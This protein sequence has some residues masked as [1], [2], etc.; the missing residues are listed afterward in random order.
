M[1]TCKHF[2]I[3]KLEQKL[4]SVTELKCTA[5]LLCDKCHKKSVKITFF[6]A[7]HEYVPT[8]GYSFYGNNIDLCIWY[9]AEF[10]DKK[11]FKNSDFI[12]LCP[13]CTKKVFVSG[14]KGYISDEEMASIKGV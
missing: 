3:K 4:I 6:M 11:W 8:V 9:N 2:R 7:P 5:R 12:N 14:Y 13:S 1:D 10:K